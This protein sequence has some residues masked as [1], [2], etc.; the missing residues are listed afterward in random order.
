MWERQCA[1]IDSFVC[2]NLKVARFY[3]GSIWVRMTN[4]IEVVFDTSM[5]SED[6]S[7]LMPP[8]SH[9]NTGH[10]KKSLDLL[11]P[12]LTSA[13]GGVSSPYEEGG[14]LYALGLIHSPVCHDNAVSGEPVSG[15]PQVLCVLCVFVCGG[16]VLHL[17]AS[18]VIYSSSLLLR[19]HCTLRCMF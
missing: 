7:N 13:A 16:Q 5:R 19:C 9:P 4:S 2:A 12:Y 15:N 17:I 14:A 10:V 11:A 6:A 3:R 1:R 8:T 18:F